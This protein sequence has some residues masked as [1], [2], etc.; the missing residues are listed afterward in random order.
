MIMKAHSCSLALPGATNFVPWHADAP[1]V[2]RVKARKVP[3]WGMNGASA[4]AVPVSPVAVT[5]PEGIVELIPYGCTRL[6]ISEFP[7]A[8]KTAQ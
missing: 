4:D 1:R 2:L 7:V 5:M 3:Q 8:A 6:R